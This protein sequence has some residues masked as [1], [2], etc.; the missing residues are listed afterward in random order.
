LW[1]KRSLGTARA[2]LVP[3]LVGDEPCCAVVLWN[4]SFPMI[5]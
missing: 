3:A 2:G 1:R 5:E 4:V